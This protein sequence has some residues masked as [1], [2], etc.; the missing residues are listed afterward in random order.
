MMAEV[1]VYQDRMRQRC[2]VQA[3]GTGRLS[4]SARRLQ[5]RVSRIGLTVGV[6][7]AIGRYGAQTPMP[8]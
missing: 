2:E 6:R 3:G 5:G 7:D 1:E 4:P 8:G